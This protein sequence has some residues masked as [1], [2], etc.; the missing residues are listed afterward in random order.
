MRHL[1]SITLKRVVI[2]LGVFSILMT[3]TTLIAAYHAVRAHISWQAEYTNF[4]RAKALPAY[5][6]IRSARR[7]DPS[8][9]QDSKRVLL[10]GDSRVQQW[11]NLPEIDGVAFKNAG[12]GGETTSELNERIAI[13]IER[14]RPDLVIIQI[15]INDLVTAR[16]EPNLAA[17]IELSVRSN[18]LSTV[19]QLRDRDI[20][21]RVFEIIRPSK[22]GFDQG[23]YEWF[24]AFV[25]RMNAQLD[26][27]LKTLNS[28]I[29]KAD[30]AFVEDSES[31]T[32]NSK[33]YVDSL[34]F[35]DAGYETLN[36]ILLENNPT[37][38]LGSPK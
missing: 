33:F 14:T 13:L 27:E 32:P 26:T 30:F 1:K 31:G 20:E 8:W 18:V 36:S 11:R 2:G 5:K 19:R 24:I 9:P 4:K 16:A 34:H 35:S 22:S 28:S 23:E 37:K 25:N 21:V 3:S 10:V 29:I 38:L 17:A 12:L 7:I 6:S 15:G